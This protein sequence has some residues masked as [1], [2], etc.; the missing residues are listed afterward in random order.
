MVSG[1]RLAQDFPEATRISPG[2]AGSPEAI[3]ATERLLE[4][5]R[6]AE[7]A[8]FVN[9][10]PTKAEINARQK[11]EGQ[12]ATRAE[13]E[14]ETQLKQAQD[15]DT[16]KLKADH[17]AA[18]D[19]LA[20]KNAGRVAREGPLSLKIEAYLK[21]WDAFEDA[22]WKHPSDNF[23]PV[24]FN[25]FAKNLVEDESSKMMI[26]RKYPELIGANGEHLDQLHSNHQ[27]MAQLAQLATQETYKDPLFTGFEQ[28]IV[29]KVWK[30]SLDM[31]DDMA[32]NGLH[33]AWIHHVSSTK[34]DADKSLTVRVKFGHGTPAADVLRG[35][36]GDWEPRS[37][38]SWPA[39]P[40][41]PDSLPSVRPSRTFV[42]LPR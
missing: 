36:P 7:K 39:S 12:A 14:M 35:V 33:P 4:A 32:R 5:Q 13:S 26:A 17:Q 22:V 19:G 31:L 27:V 21:A 25:I 23:E 9:S 20:A 30:S 3:Q 37:S 40:M 6:D 18:R 8:E 29:E 38:T 11:A 10:L 28:A 2:A 42:I 34:A 16:A 1:V 41:R 15:H 24:F